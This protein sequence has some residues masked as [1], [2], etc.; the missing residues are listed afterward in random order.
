[1]T[2]CLIS[3]SQKRN[4]LTAARKKHNI[5]TGSTEALRTA[6]LHRTISA[7]DDDPVSWSARD[8]SIPHKEL[9]K[10]YLQHNKAK[11]RTG[12]L[13]LTREMKK[14]ERGRGR[15]SNMVGQSTMLSFR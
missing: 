14:R 15:E 6:A 5:A 10:D 8:Q 11:R 12:Q 9:A 3:A 7:D 1:M 4:K 2:M 13:R